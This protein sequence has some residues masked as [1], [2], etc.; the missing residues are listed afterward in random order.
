MKKEELGAKG[1]IECSGMMTFLVGLE[2]FG[3]RLILRKPLSS[4]EVSL[5]FLRRIEAVGIWEAR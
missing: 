2:V 5:G 4:A 3:G 1:I